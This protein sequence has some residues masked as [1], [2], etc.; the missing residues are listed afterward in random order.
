M[1]H[2]PSEAPIKSAGGQVVMMLVMQGSHPQHPQHYLAR[3]PSSAFHDLCI[4]DSLPKAP[5][6]GA[7][8]FG[9][10]SF[11]Q[12]HSC[13]GAPLACRESFPRQ[14]IG[15]WEL[16]LPFRSPS[17]LTIVELNW[18]EFG[19][20]TWVGFSACAPDCLVKSFSMAS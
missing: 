11:L 7:S 1:P 2:G 6:F 13:W 19:S 5:F 17:S 9:S 14:N 15:F 3:V 4:H 16:L 18:P 12:K 20:L 8:L 10:C